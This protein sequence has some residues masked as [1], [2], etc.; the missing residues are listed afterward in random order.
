MDTE[1]TATGEKPNP[2]ARWIS[3]GLEELRHEFAKAPRFDPPFHCDVVIVGSGYGGAVAAAELAGCYDAE[4]GKQ[5]RVCVLE[6]GIEYLPGM[7]PT[8]EADLPGH[9]RFS[10]PGNPKPRGKQE[11]LLDVRVGPNV[12]SLVACGLGGGSLINAG[13]MVPV[14]KDA[15]K[16][17]AWPEALDWSSVSDSYDEMKRRLGASIQGDD[18][19]IERNPHGIPL[20]FT[21]LKK[22]RPSAFSAAPLSI[23]MTEDTNLS[24]VSLSACN[25]CGDCATG[26]NHGAKNSL[27]ENL[28]VEAHRRG[29]EI[30]TG[31]TVT[32]LAKLPQGG[33]TLHVVHTDAAVRRRAGDPFELRARRVILAAGTFGSTEILLR[34]VSED[35]RFSQLLGQRFSANGDA[36]AVV[37]GQKDPVNALACESNDPTP[38]ALSKGREVGPTITGIIDRCNKPRAP[39]VIEEFSIP[40]PLRRLF[41]ESFALARCLDD[42][43]KPDDQTHC[44]AEKQQQDPVAIDEDVLR[45]TQVFGLM[46]HDGAGGSLELIEPCTGDDDVSDGA[47]RV[48]WSAVRDDAR[49]RMF[50]DQISI[51]RNLVRGAK[52]GGQV[53]PNPMWRPLPAK[54]DGVLD[55]P[56]GPIFTVHPLG[57]CP[58]GK[59]PAHGVVDDTGRV[60]DPRDPSDPKGFHD[61]LAVLDGSMIPSSLGVNPALTIAAIALRGVRFLRTQWGLLENKPSRESASAPPLKLV[62]PRFAKP[63]HRPAAPTCVA[64]TERMS[65]ALL[66]RDEHGRKQRRFVELTMRFKPTAIRDFTARLDRKLELDP[67]HCRL[68]TFLPKDW[69]HLNHYKCDEEDFARRAQGCYTLDG[70][71]IVL[72]REQSSKRQRTT[73]ATWAWLL[74]RGL[75]D[76]WQWFW[77]FSWRGRF[78]REVCRRRHLSSALA[79]RAGEAR[80]FKYDLALVRADKPDPEIERAGTRS[81]R[82]YKRYTY[83]RKANLWQQLQDLHLTEFPGA[84]SSWLHKPVLTLDL[85]FLAR[86]RVPLLELTSQDNHATALFD[87]AS[88]LAYFA[89]LAISIHTWSLR[90]PDSQKPRESDRLPRR[91]RGLP[92]AEVTEIEVGRHTDGTVARVRLTR[93]ARRNSPHNPLIMIHGYS[94]SGT[95]FAHPA[96]RPNMASYMWKRN[97]DVWILDLR[98]SSGMPTAHLPW[99]FEEAAHEDIP[100]ALTHIER[101]VRA[102]RNG[103]AKLGLS[104]AAERPLKL[105]V[106]AHC[107][108]SA[109]MTM[110]I[111]GRPEPGAKFFKER[112][113]LPKLIEHLII[114]QVAPTTVFSAGNVFRAYA[115]GYLRNLLPMAEYQFRP[116]HEPSPMDQML[117][118]VL[119]TMPYPEE[120]FA[121][122]NPLWPWK[123]TPWVRTRHRMDALYGRDFNLKNIPPRVLR[124]IDD[125]FGP[126]NMDTVLSAI[127]FARTS[128]ITNRAGRNVYV[129]RSRL[130]EHWRDIKTLCVSGRDNG[131]ADVATA[132]QMKDL[133]ADAGVHL[134]RTF[135]KEDYGHQDSLIG[136]DAV[137][138]FEQMH[139]FLADP[140]GFQSQPEEQRPDWLRD[141]LGECRVSAPW[142]GPV[143]GAWIPAEQTLQIGI[144]PD[145]QI[146]VP[147][148]VAIVEVDENEGRYAVRFHGGAGIVRERWNGYAF[149]LTSFDVPLSKLGLKTS[150]GQVLVLFVYDAPL[151]KHIEPEALDK[152]VRD[153]VEKFLSNTPSDTLRTALVC[154]AQELQQK[155]DHPQSQGD[156]TVTFAIGSCQYPAGAFDKKLAS[157]SFSR[158]ATLVDSN[159]QRKPSFLVLMGDQIYSDAT[160]GLFDPSTSEDRYVLPYENWL[161]TDAVRRVLQRLPSYMMLDD[162]E[163]EDNWEPVQASEL[164]GREALELGRK[165][166]FSYQRL[167]RSQVKARKHTGQ[168][169]WHAATPD[170]LRFFF[171]DTRTDRQARTLAK[172]DVA[173]MIGPDQMSDLKAWLSHATESGVPNFVVSSAMLLPRKIHHS[174]TDTAAYRA[175]SWQGYP[176]TFHEVLA[177]IANERPRTL[178]FL[179]GDEHHSCVARVTVQNLTARTPA[180][181]FHSIHC[182]GLYSP[183]PFANGKPADLI[184]HDS[185]EFKWGD[186]EYRC[187]VKV[188]EDFPAPGDGFAT[189]QCVRTSEDWQ[190][191][192]RFEPDRGERILDTSLQSHSPSPDRVTREVEGEA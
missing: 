173:S 59:D 113:R 102:E 30:Y 63:Q 54:L 100:A 92:K 80:L 135:I 128:L 42:L 142:L 66:L 103:R 123:K 179:S 130:N 13:V 52:G 192:C 64:V 140:E 37:Y 185:F 73:R 180:V 12:C 82:G 95:T 26:C 182:S 27:D 164:E 62:R 83:A 161:Q 172:L 44:P 178:V 112:E 170:G 19:T 114:S 181:I 149:G 76:G 6:R 50:D 91:T 29:A 51:L 143:R 176:A 89:R 138:V 189:I 188:E 147:S 67:A 1:S 174:D 115:M 107:M 158:L 104:G 33:W 31:A 10:T 75:R 4:A 47:I 2:A 46:G 61:R 110:A 28:L 145:P 36:M 77:S 125:L 129:K 7:F 136:R 15:W 99:T 116:R 25:Q 23:S 106:I 71:L 146:G 166:Y 14:K 94:A 133:M 53:L 144:A 155:V 148:Y 85:R 187:E 141:K 24:G 183:F 57:G 163:I 159:D 165:G 131:L 41:A 70:S 49:F 18:N 111:L 117:D 45:R 171:A 17:G 65:G 74:N 97:R 169:L 72:D 87:I 127:H 9:V 22:L 8:T 151:E 162:H 132:Y 38:S 191:S 69:Q 119:A 167:A 39:G 190:V 98:T 48:R 16:E 156:P 34:S 35:L 137:D 121:I 134:F 40:G 177:Q 108:G 68:R 3:R 60:F 21:A 139:S 184:K 32:K 55:V 81:I 96:V 105:D 43:A 79:S 153:A 20:K 86:L 11:G 84:H 124:Y 88:F 152:L 120:E 118:R 157:A 126:L 58:M 56:K 122:E 154:D 101:I 109:M 168:P 160:A 78:W 90:K 93:F 150:A 186:D 175:D 5:A